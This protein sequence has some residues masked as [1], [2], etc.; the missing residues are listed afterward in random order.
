MEPCQDSSETL[1]E[2]P[3]LHTNDNQQAQSERFRESL[4]DNDVHAV[5]AGWA[6]AGYPCYSAAFVL[7]QL[8]HQRSFVTMSNDVFG[9]AIFLGLAAPMLTLLT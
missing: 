3:T 7:I 9:F 4:D 5:L 8:W 1:S 6:V 2:S